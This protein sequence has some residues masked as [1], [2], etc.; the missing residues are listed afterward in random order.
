MKNEQIVNR[1]NSI[2]TFM[3]EIYNE[4]IKINKKLDDKNLEQI[5]LITRLENISD[6][7]KDRYDVLVEEKSKFIP[8]SV[9]NNPKI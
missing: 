7:I 9:E 1:L 5:Q 8:E 4:I 6:F 3:E 2:E